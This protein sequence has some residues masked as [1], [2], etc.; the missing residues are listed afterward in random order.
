M[1]DY[2]PEQEVKTEEVAEK[3]KT[4]VLSTTAQAKRRKLA[5][6]RQNRGESMEVDE[7]KTPKPDAG[8]VD[9]KDDDTSI[10]DTGKEV[11]DKDKEGEKESP[12]KKIEKEKVGY[13]LENM[14]R[15]LPGQIKYISFPQDGRYQPVKKVRKPHDVDIAFNEF[16][17]TYASSPLV[18]QSSFST[19]TRTNPNLSSSSRPRRRPRLPHPHRRH[20][21]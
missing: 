10:V 14:S 11:D 4:A 13:D 6:D 17:L 7:P 12:K 16:E 21:A 2:P 20:P 15:V 9:M 3:V 1:F 5:K 8:D 18:V 19:K